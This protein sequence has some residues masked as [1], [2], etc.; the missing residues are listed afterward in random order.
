M[1]KAWMCAFAAVLAGQALAQE[2]AKAGQEKVAFE[3]KAFPF[4]GEVSADRLN[5]RLYPKS[6][7]TSIIASVLGLGDKVTVVAE[8]GEFY[9]VLPPK[10]CTVWVSARNVKREGGTGIVTAG[11]VPVRLDSRVNADALGTLKEGEAVKVL[12][13][14]MGWLKI[15]APAS[16]KYFVAR[17]FVRAGRE[18]DAASLPAAAQG[19]GRRPAAPTPA[20]AVRTGSDDEARAALRVADSF[21]EEQRKLIDER[22]L[23]QVDF[24]AVVAAYQKA[25]ETAADPS[26]KAEADTLHKR[27]RDLHLIWTTA[28]EEKARKEAELA[29][30]RA[31]PEAKPAAAKPYVMMGFVDTTG[32]TLFKRP[33]THKLIMGGKIVAFLRAKDGEERMISRFNDLYQKYV[34]VNG[35]LIKNPD[36]WDGYTVVVVDQIVPIQEQ[37]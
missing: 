11:D 4:E 6:D 16:V 35:I 10:G 32:S 31:P 13:E 19:A 7:G 34:G 2:P 9:Q 29:A 28:K 26:V 25:S 5:V 20:G 30:L 24:S 17:K 27:Y 23:D 14:N 8:Q 21:L 12:G 1:R 22:K 3:K 15:E 18:L 37:P 33:G 36:G